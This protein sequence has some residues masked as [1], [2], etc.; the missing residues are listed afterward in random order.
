MLNPSKSGHDL[1]F[2]PKDKSVIRNCLYFS[3]SRYGILIEHS[4]RN[5]SESLYI[6]VPFS[7]QADWL[8][9]VRASM[10]T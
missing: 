9:H 2:S 1:S 5:A 8:R 4:V 6:P 7:R 3:D 10:F